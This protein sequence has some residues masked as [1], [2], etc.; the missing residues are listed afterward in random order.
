MIYDVAT[1]VLL[2]R[3]RDEILRSLVGIPVLSSTL[4]DLAPQE[5]ATV[6]RVDFAIRLITDDGSRLLVLL[7]IQSRWD[8]QIPLRLLEYRTRHLL[9]EGL[10]VLSAVLLLKPA[11]RAADFYQDSEVTFRFKLIP[12]YAM[13]GRRILDE[14]NLCL[15]PLV[16]IMKG[17]EEI[18][19]EAQDL[20]AQSPLPPVV[21]ADMLASMALLSGLVSKRLASELI[22]RRRDIMNESAAYEIIKNE[23]IKEGFQQGLQTGIERGIEQGIEQGKVQEA[24]EAVLDNLEARFGAVPVD[25]VRRIYGTSDLQHLKELRRQSATVPTLQAFMEVVE[26]KP[27]RRRRK[28]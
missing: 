28:R 15:I 19:F 20:L 11:D 7:E 12:V 6:R 23:G 9:Q 17:G 10:P 24:Q 14:G 21:K 26:E 3:C 2:D 4:L 1:K 22:E 25:L 5:T 18:A 8:E 27:R 13:D 16:P